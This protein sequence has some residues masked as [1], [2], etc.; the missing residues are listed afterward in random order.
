MGLPV[1]VLLLTATGLWLANK[2]SSV[3]ATIDSLN[4]EALTMARLE[5][6]TENRNDW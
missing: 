6:S 2:Y 5:A 1:A 4:A 3:H